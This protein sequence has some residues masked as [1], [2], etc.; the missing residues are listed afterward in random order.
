M[1]LRL[2]TDILN[3]AH[4]RV[5]QAWGVAVS[6]LMP[7][8]AE[9]FDGAAQRLYA[10][11]SELDGADPHTLHA[12]HWNEKGTA[13]REATTE[14]ERLRTVR[15]AYALWSGSHRNPVGSIRY[16]VS[17]RTGI[18]RDNN[19]EQQFS[20]IVR[21]NREKNYWILLAQFEGAQ[22]K[23]QTIE[24]QNAQPWPASILK[25]QA[26]MHASVEAHGTTRVQVAV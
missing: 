20:F 17:S 8:F 11:L 6:D 21:N 25:Y 2:A 9:K 16:E 1:R 22:I 14:L 15:D 10:A 7:Q 3:I 18:F 23:W 12:E 26:Q 24:E 13:L 4:A 19:H 5:E